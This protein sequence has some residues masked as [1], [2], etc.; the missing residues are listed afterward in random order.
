MTSASGPGTN[1]QRMA[2]AFIKRQ[3]D[4]NQRMLL[5]SGASILASVKT[6]RRLN[7]YIEYFTPRDILP[8]F[9][10]FAI[11]VLAIGMPQYLRSRRIKNVLQQT[12]AKECNLESI[13]LRLFKF[14]T[15]R[16]IQDEMNGLYFISQQKTIATFS[17]PTLCAGGSG[18]DLV[19]LD[20][21]QKIRFA[22]NLRNPAPRWRANL[23]L[24]K[25][26]ASKANLLQ[27]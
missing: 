10:A 3:K 14:F 21:K 16:L 13:E 22:I 7:P 27:N 26:L 6:A 9:V 4:L 24:A 2:M 15:I 11:L 12:E 23:L 5:A 17:P 20:D 19:M 18:A 8:Y 1:D 25:R